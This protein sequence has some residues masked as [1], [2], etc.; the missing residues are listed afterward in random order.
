MK[1]PMKHLTTALLIV[2][3][4]G[5][6]VAHAANDAASPTGAATASAPMPNG[7]IRKVD[8]ASG[9]VTIKHGPLQNLDMPGMVMVFRVKDAAWLEQ[10]K[11][12]DKIR[13]VA[14]RV[15]GLLTVVQYEP[16]K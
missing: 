1:Q 4:L 13:F 14:D 11:A 12:G 10:M 2:L 8:K 9:K 16:A 6:P 7:E 5:L 3:A 15:N